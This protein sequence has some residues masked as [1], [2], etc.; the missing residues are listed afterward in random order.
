MTTPHV[1]GTSSRLLHQTVRGSVWRAEWATEGGR[2]IHAALD[3]DMTERLARMSVGTDRHR[4]AGEDPVGPLRE[5]LPNGLGPHWLVVLRDAWLGILF[6][7]GPA[8]W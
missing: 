5:P 2:R 8:R 6:G 1:T 7:T 4:W 3:L